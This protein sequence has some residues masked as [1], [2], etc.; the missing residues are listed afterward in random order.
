MVLVAKAGL[1]KG[2]ACIHDFSQSQDWTDVTVPDTS[3]A[4]GIHGERTQSPFSPSARRHPEPRKALGW[5]CLQD[6]EASG[7]RPRGLPGNQ[8][9]PV[10]GV[11]L[12]ES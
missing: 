5:R 7:A 11:E 10:E 2:L 12:A 4:L 6:S 1:K 9:H 3:W 8:G